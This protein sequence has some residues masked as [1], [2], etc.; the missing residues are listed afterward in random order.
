M[1]LPIVVARPL[2][3]LLFFLHNCYIRKHLRESDLIMLRLLVFR[4]EISWRPPS[5]K[6]TGHR[7]RQG[8]LAPTI[9]KGES[10]NW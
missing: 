8:R 10:R 7:R 9:S 2:D 6:V 3:F 4:K 1:D 5:G